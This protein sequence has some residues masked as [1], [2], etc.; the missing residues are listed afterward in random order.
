MDVIS[1]AI[2]HG[3]IPHEQT[4]EANNDHHCNSYH[5]GIGWD[6]KCCPRFSRSSQVDQSKENN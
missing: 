6:R 1:S 4:D 2:R 3:K 5:V